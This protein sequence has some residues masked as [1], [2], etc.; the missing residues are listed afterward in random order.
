M[1]DRNVKDLVS[2]KEKLVYFLIGLNAGMVLLL[3]YENVLGLTH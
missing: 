1:P 3:I 2:F